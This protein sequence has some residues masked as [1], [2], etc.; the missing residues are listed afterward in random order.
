M[1]L[2]PYTDTEIRITE[3]KRL[4]RPLLLAVWL[5]MAGFSITEG[6][7][8][9]LLA[10]S[11]AVGVSLL[12]AQVGCEVYVRRPLLN[13]G[14]ILATAVMFLE[15]FAGRQQLI[16]ILGHYLILIEICKLFDRRRNR[17]YVQL[18]AIS[19][20]LVVTGAMLCEDLWYALLLLCELML[21]SHTAMRLTLKRGLDDTVAARL[22]VEGAAPEP[23][24]AAWNM[25][26]HWPTRALLG[27]LGVILAVVSVLGG[28]MFLVVPR[29]AAGS[30][31]L[32][33]GSRSAATSGYSGSVQ[34]GQTREVYLSDRT[35][36]RVHVDGN[37][38]DP[39]SWYLRGNTLEQYA[40]SRWFGFQPGQLPGLSSPPPPR[41]DAPAGEV[42]VQ[43]V[44]QVQSLA[45]AMFG[46]APAIRVFGETGEGR[47]GGDGTLSL[48]REPSPR[49]YARYTVHSWAR[50]LSEEQLAYL[51]ERQEAG[52]A[53]RPYVHTTRRVEVLA[54]QWC[55][56]LLARR[57]TEPRRR[58][59]LD[60]RIAGR[61]AERLREE[62]AYTLDLKGSDPKRDGVEDF[63]FHMKR[64]HCEYFASA[65]T[66]MCNIVGV[67]AR[68]ATGFRID[69][70]GANEG[71]YV[72]RERDA[73]AWTEV[74]TPAT[75][76][77]VFD[78]TPGDYADIQRSWWS[79]LTDYW[80]GLQQMWSEQVLQ[81][82]WDTQRK[83]WGMLRS[84]VLRAYHWLARVG[85]TVW[86]AVLALLLHGELHGVLIPAAAGL[87]L[88]VLAMELTILRRRS[89]RP[90]SWRGHAW[91]LVPNRRELRF[92]VDLLR[93]LERH[94]VRAGPQHTPRHIAA[95]AAQ[96]LHL[97]PGPLEDLV[98][99]YYRLR[100]GLAPATDDDLRAARAHVRSL[101]DTL[102]R[103]P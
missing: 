10:G 53:V 48:P 41:P 86:E 45:P 82:D 52:L 33:Q 19:M 44:T 103:R 73:H 85:G 40:D 57:Q 81:Y 94:G 59:E 71:D 39:G 91:A 72:I 93:L 67:R 99:L 22:S 90:R 16:I 102:R 77:V 64:G 46:I 11:A 7:M 32:L 54:R 25:M 4:E 29:L 84:G 92:M 1:P 26:R 89:L 80:S 42:L 69:P 95:L 18:L 23:R 6:A 76:W 98:A 66:V 101:R 75:D 58:N 37:L 24:R 49:P 34:L 27:R 78:A 83:L 15:L 74:Y 31:A 51:A 47:V 35:V 68:L 63:L 38:D 100:W 87:G 88:A 8:F 2:R 12:A 43:E 62:Y 13:T 97:P 14:L 21:L 28:V 70:A 79:P 20:L 5:A 17:D 56:D 61:I 55:A 9:Y 65:M 3:R 50:P 30:A 36:M 96:R 60:L